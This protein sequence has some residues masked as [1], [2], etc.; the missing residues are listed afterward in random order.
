M[1]ETTSSFDAQ[2]TLA[3]LRARMRA[4]PDFPKPG[5]L[6]RDITPILADSSALADALALHRGQVAD[7]EGGIDKIVGMESRGFLFG[8]ALAA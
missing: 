6:F 2:A 1:S 5:I 4:V 8:M 7:L 3:R